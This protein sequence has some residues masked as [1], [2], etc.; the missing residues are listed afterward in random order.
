MFDKIADFLTGWRFAAFII[1][2]CVTVTLI[3]MGI[4]LIPNAASGVGAFAQDFKTWCFGYDPATGGYQWGLTLVMILNPL[5][6]A[7]FV[8]I[9][10]S[11]SLHQAMRTSLYAVVTTAG[12][13]VFVAGLLGGGLFVIGPKEVSAK[14]LP[15]PAERIRTELE[16]PQFEL[17]DQ[18]GDKVSLEGLRGRVV[19]LTAIYASCNTACPTIMVQARKATNALP[20]ELRDEVTI[21]AVTLDPN[22]DTP[23]RLK[24]AAKAHHVEAPLWRLVTGE[25]DTVNRVLDKMSVSRRINPDTGVIEHSNLFALI[26]RDGKI[27]Y[28]LTL[29]E[30]HDTWLETALRQLVHEEKKEDEGKS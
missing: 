16:P 7:G 22:N 11:N 2:L 25:P 6:L 5:L 4:M 27:A 20:E 1:T 21:V 8:Y 17:T 30:R 18:N 23:D 15:F 29:G 19:L 10:W 14:Q 12:V 13:G 3:L 24:E 28:R 9:V 26:D